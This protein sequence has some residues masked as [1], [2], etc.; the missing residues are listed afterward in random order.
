MGQQKKKTALLFLGLVVVLVALYGAVGG[1]VVQKKLAS[2]AATEQGT[3]EGEFK[4]QGRALAEAKEEIKALQSERERTESAKAGRRDSITSAELAPYL[5]GVM[6]LKCG[7]SLGSASLW[8]VREEGMPAYAVLTNEHVVDPWRE[9]CLILP[10]SESDD[11]RVVTIDTS[12]RKNWNDD[13]DVALVPIVNVVSL[14]KK[15]N[16]PIEELNYTISSLPY[17]SPQMEIGAPVVA[18]GFPAFGLQE[19]NRTDGSYTVAAHQIASNGILSGYT[20][21]DETGKKLP[22]SNYFV[23]A[24]ID[25][26]NS[27]GIVLSKDDGLCVLGIATWVSVGNY[28]TQGLVQ[29]IYN[30]MHKE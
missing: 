20:G 27:G 14:P 25:T 9:H 16:V 22:F 7:N 29:N 24:K 17:C 1:F 4:R 19:V 11:S 26:G 18:I 10:G 2:A 8:R 28:E 23:S 6:Q 15:E 5:S 12:K 13:A 21:M 30:V 3:F